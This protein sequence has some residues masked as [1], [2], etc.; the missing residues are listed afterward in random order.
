MAA[1]DD[2]VVVV[3]HQGIE[4]V[5]VQLIGVDVGRLGKGGDDVGDEGHIQLSRNQLV[6]HPQGGPPLDVDGDAAVGIL[7]QKGGDGGS[8]PHPAHVVHT[9]DVQMPAVGEPLDGGHHLV[10]VGQQLSG[11]GLELPACGRQRHHRRLR[12]NRRTFSSSSSLLIC[13][14]RAD[15]ELETSK[16]AFVKLR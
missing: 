9:A 2:G 16:A 10:I 14:D 8:Q 5:V 7:L 3:H 12:S 6:H 1:A 11:V 15:W 13:L 4:A